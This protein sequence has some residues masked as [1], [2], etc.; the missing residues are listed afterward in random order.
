MRQITLDE[1]RCHTSSGLEPIAMSRVPQKVPNRGFNSSV[2]GS[3]TSSILL[4]TCV[5]HIGAPERI[6]DQHILLF[7][8]LSA[9]WARAY[10]QAT[11]H[12]L[13]RFATQAETSGAVLF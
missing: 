1:V 10:L 3:S 9:F 11:T 13:N 5:Q 8:G 12:G 6:A 4:G 7:R 2:Q